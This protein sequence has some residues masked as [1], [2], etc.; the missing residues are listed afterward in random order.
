MPEYIVGKV[1]RRRELHAEV[2][3]QR[4]GGISTPSKAPV[5]LLFTGEQGAQY[6]YHDGFQD[7]DTY[8]YTGEGQVGDMQFV[9]G[10]AAIRDHQ[11]SG[12]ALHL[13]QYVRTA[14]VQYVGPAFYLR[15]FERLAPDR[16]GALRQVIVFVLAVGAPA[17]G[18]PE[19]NP[20]PVP[21]PPPAFSKKTMAELREE[22]Y[23]AS[24]FVR[25]ASERIIAAHYRSDVVKAYVLRRAGGRC[26]GC[27][28][29]APFLNTRGIPYLEPHHVRRRAD[30]GPDHPR[31]VIALCP[32]CHARVHRSVDGREY[33]EML[34]DRLGTIELEYSV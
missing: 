34:A 19:I 18:T 24:T 21:S 1:Y 12:K 17:E 4:Q 14:H 33:N 29:E 8:W 5:V 30:G 25:A 32:N 28:Q 27:E 13:F 31:W 26:E 3:G 6:G 2:D 9:R 15:H 7:D 20:D 16:D 22:A 23:A 11:Q 10:N